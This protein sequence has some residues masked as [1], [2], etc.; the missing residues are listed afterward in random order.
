M[1]IDRQSASTR[2]IESRI[3]AAQDYA[4]KNARRL[5]SG[6]YYR[7]EY[8]LVALKGPGIV[9]GTNLPKSADTWAGPFKIVKRY[10]SGS[11]QLKELD[12]TIL[13]GA[14]P[15]SHL[16]PFYTRKNQ[17]RKDFLLSEEDSSDG[18]D[19]FS[20]SEEEEDRRDNDY[21]ITNA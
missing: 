1:R 3:K 11:Y 7:N 18:F 15:M 12:G 19:P 17:Q 4:A 5:V 2:N 6:Q 21:R 10:K 8:V 9:R 13:K 20:T 16:K 14:I